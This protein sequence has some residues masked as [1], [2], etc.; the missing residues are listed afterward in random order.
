MTYRQTISPPTLVTAPESE[1]LTLGEAKKHLEIASSETAHDD[2]LS[3]L[4]QAARE[5]WE[6][7]TDAA[8]LTQT[9]SV[10]L[11]DWGCDIA[12]PKR[13][14]QSITSVTYYDTGNTQQ[15][16]ATTVYSLD[17]ARRLVRLKY[18]QVWPAQADRWDAITVTYVAGYTS[19]ALVPAVVKQAMLLLVGRY[20]EDR[21]E[22]MSDA[23]K[24][25]PAYD[26][27]VKRFM[28]SSYP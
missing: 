17:A 20:F 12:L 23:M 22:L 21:D 28:R 27:L 25:M 18:N 19:A 3:L 24:A 2:Q 11:N 7:D 13:P 9:W 16:L 6:H 1:P 8:V 10:T 15:T 4:I 26:N 14:L 5:Q